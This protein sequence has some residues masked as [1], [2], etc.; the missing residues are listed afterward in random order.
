M[1]QSK[2]S[3]V[4]TGL[5]IKFVNWSPSDESLGYY[6][7]SLR[8]NVLLN[9][10]ATRIYVGQQGLTLPARHE[11]M[12]T[13]VVRAMVVMPEMAAVS[14]TSTESETAAVIGVEAAESGMARSQIDA[15]AGTG[16]SISVTVVSRKAV[17]SRIG[18]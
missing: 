13:S 4:P 7:K 15:D 8:D 1:M 16:K 12:M 3:V 9:D 11:L 18:A 10:V 17:K 6:Q 2:I 14:E 5:K